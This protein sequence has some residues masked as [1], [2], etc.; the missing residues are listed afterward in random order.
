MVHGNIVFKETHAYAFAYPWCSSHVHWRASKNKTKNCIFLIFLFSY[1]RTISQH[2]IEHSAQSAL[3]A[4]LNGV[5]SGTN[6][7]WATI[8]QGFCGK[9]EIELIGWHWS[10][11]QRSKCEPNDLQRPEECKPKNIQAFLFRLQPF[12]KKMT[13][14][15]MEFELQ[16][17][18]RI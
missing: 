15:C 17:E 6:L 2:S 18:R 4:S 3:S 9:K 16:L 12:P 8:L 1:E 11:N 7:S 10:F 5:A 13:Y 14:T